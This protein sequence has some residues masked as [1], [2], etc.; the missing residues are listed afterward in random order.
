MVRREGQ[1]PSTT[2]TKYVMRRR[3]QVVMMMLSTMMRMLSGVMRMLGTRRSDRKPLINLFSRSIT[4]V[5]NHQNVL[6]IFSLTVVSLC[7]L[8]NPR[9][10]HPSP[11]VPFYPLSNPLDLPSHIVAASPENFRHR[12]CRQTPEYSSYILSDFSLALYPSK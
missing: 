11:I 2:N 12:L 4:S 6:P 9:R 10:H 1:K 3:R 7:I 5:A 8:L